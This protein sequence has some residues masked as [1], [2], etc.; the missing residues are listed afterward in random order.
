[1]PS[2]EPAS[3]L[4]LPHFQPLC[5]VS[6]RYRFIYIL[7]AKN[8]SISMRTEFGLDRY[9]AHEETYAELPAES[10]CNYFTFAVLREHVEFDGFLMV[11]GLA[12]A[13]IAAEKA[14][15]AVYDRL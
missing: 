9:A 8:A 4:P 15:R 13:M 5:C 3:D 14:T 11:I 6:D 7:I 10:R 12:A 2:E 1:M